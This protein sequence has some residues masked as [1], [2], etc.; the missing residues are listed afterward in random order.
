[1]TPTKKGFTLLEVMI[2]LAIFVLA[3]VV[4]GG[5]YVNVLASY[6]AANRMLQ[7]N[8]DVQFAREALLAESDPEVVLKGGDF[9][10]ANNRHVQWKATMELT[11]TTDVFQV[12]FDVVITAPDLKKAEATHE[13]FRV[14]R[15]TWSKGTDRE[16]IRAKNRDRITKILTTKK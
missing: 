8:E 1:M 5:A 15:P 13:T 10:G 14:L 7:R 11:E 12:L 2:A 9:E 6:E 16:K 3:A 4:L